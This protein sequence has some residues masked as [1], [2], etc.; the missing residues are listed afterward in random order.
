MCAP[1]IEEVSA[2]VQWGETEKIPR[3]FFKPRG[4]VSRYV[5]RNGSCLPCSP[6]YDGKNYADCDKNLCME[7]IFV[8]DA[9]IAIGELLLRRDL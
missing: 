4:V 3:D 8:K 6:C 7:N 2:R 5:L 9:E 1:I